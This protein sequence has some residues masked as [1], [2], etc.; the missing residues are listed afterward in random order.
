MS[1][2]IL[3]VQITSVAETAET[4]EEFTRQRD[5]IIAV[6]NTIDADIVGLVE[7]E[8]NA[9]ESLSDLVNGLNADADAGTYAL[10]TQGL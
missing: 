4:A 1:V 10:L 9:T 6:I 7:I 3:A 5:K 8:N 2:K